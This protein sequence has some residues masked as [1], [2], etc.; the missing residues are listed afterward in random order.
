M[1]TTEKVCPICENTGWKSVGSGAEQRVTRCDCRISARAQRVLQMARIPRRYEHCTFASYRTDFAGAHKSLR[2]ALLRAERFAE[3]YPLDRTG[4]LF[5]G[6]VGVGKT[7]LS[8]AI[9]QELIVKKGIK[10]LFYEYGELLAEVKHSYSPAISTTEL[11]VLRP[12]L[13]AE[14]LVLDE[15]GAQRVS[16]WVWDTV[17]HILNTRYNANLT[18]IITTNFP[19]L[20]PKNSD[21]AVDMFS[22]AKRAVRVETLGDRITE[23]MRSRLHEMCRKVEMEGDDYRIAFNGTLKSRAK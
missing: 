1:T 4:L 17:S 19:D 18:T 3:D 15:L 14:V 12:I 8:V 7:H 2:H 11:D 9:L 21:E 5:V 22:K 13:E 23:R 16:E 10:C 20:P 6:P